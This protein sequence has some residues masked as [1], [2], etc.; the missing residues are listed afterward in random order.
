MKTIFFFGNCQTGAIKN[1]LNLNS[2]DYKI[3]HEICHIT[4]LN[5]DEFTDIINKSDIIITQNIADNYRGFDYLN[6]NYILDNSKDKIIIIIPSCYFN[7]YYP[8]LKYIK[9]NSNTL[10]DHVDYH[11]QYMIDNFKN[12][13]TV[14]NYITNYVNNINLISEEKLLE[15]ANNSIK[16]LKNRTQQIKSKLKCQN[17]HNICIA[18]FI[19]NNYRDKLLFY[20]MNHPTKYIIEYIAQEI[21]QIL[22]INNNIN[23]NTDVLDNTKCILYKCIQPLVNFDISKEKIKTKDQTD[24]FHITK[25]YYETYKRIDFEIT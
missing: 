4:N 23:Y 9:N 3:Y 17:V 20:S 25:L 18:D 11:Y 12:N 13:G 10:H 6:L 22:N 16:E 14:E 8:D 1:K 7:F 5:K 15:N 21:I 24:V 19:E 2:Y